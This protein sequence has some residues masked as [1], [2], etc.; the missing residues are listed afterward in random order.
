[1]LTPTFATPVS[2]F[3][4][5]GNTPAVSLIQTLPPHEDARILHLGC[6]DIRNILFTCY[7]N[8]ALRNLD[9]TCCDIECAILARNILLLSVL[10]DDASNSSVNL[11]WNIN[12]HLYLNRQDANSIYTQVDKL[13]DQ[14]DSI[15]TW[16][17]SRYGR[18]FRFCD[19]ESFSKVKETWHS[20]LVA[21]SNEAAYIKKFK[22]SIQKA[23]DIRKAHVG[24]GIVLTGVRSAAP[25]GIYAITD[26]SKLHGYFWEHGSTDSNKDII[27]KSGF[28]NPTFMPVTTSSNLHYGSDPLLGFHL[29]LGY[30]PLISEFSSRADKLETSNF[31]RAV[32]AARREFQMWCS[33][34]KKCADSNLI[35]RF[36]WADALTMCHTLQVVSLNRET[37]TADWYSGAY[38]SD[39]LVLD[40]ED[41]HTTGAAPLSFN[42]IDTSNL[43]DHLGAINLLAA[44]SPLLENTASSSLFTESLVKREKNSTALL[45]NLLSYDF[46]TMTVVLCLYPIEY[47]T[48][49]TSASGFDEGMMDTVHGLMEKDTV[50]SSS[51][52]MRHRILWKR[53]MTAIKGFQVI[54]WKAAELAMMFY[55][56][57]KNMFRH[58]NMQHLFSG[59]DLHSIKNMS[60]PH[61]HRGSLALLL[62]FAKDNCAADWDEVIK[63]FLNLIEKDSLV[64]MTNNYI[65]EFYVYLHIFGVHTVPTLQRTFYENSRTQQVDGLGSWLDLPP[66]VC[67]TLNI[68]KKSLNVLLNAPVKRVGTPILH[69]ILQSSKSST[70]KPWQNIFSEVHLVFGKIVTHG[71][72]NE[73]SFQV[74]IVEDMYGWNGTSNL[75]ASFYIPTWVALFDPKNAIVSLGIQS[76]PPSATYFGPILGLELNL[77][78]T[79][80]ANK[81]NVYITKHYPQLP[82]LPKVGCSIA[83]PPATNTSPSN[84]ISTIIITANMDQRCER[85][86]SF[87]GRLELL[88]NRIKR[89]LLDGAK[90]ET[91]QISMCVMTVS[92]NNVYQFELSFPTGIEGSRRK[93]RIA[94]TSSYV[95]VI[96]PLTNPMSWGNYPDS[97]YPMLMQNNPINFNMPYLC[98]NSLPIIDIKQKKEL[99]WLNTHLSAMWSL[100]ERRQREAG[101]ESGDIRVNFKDSLFSIFMH[102]TALQG[103]KAHIFGINHS[104]RGGIHILIFVNCLRLDMGNQTV[105]LDAAVIP[106]TDRIVTQNSRFFSILPKRGVC[107][108]MVDD[109]ELV[110]WRRVIPAWVERCREWDHK[111]SCEYKSRTQIPLAAKDGENPLCCCG[112]GLLTSQYMPDFPEWKDVSKH[113]LRAAI[114]P[115]FPVPYIEEVFSVDDLREFK[116]KADKCNTCGKQ[117]AN[118]TQLKNCGKC[119]QAKYCSVECQRRDWKAHKKVC[120]SLD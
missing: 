111:P 36:C 95:E 89:T 51:G 106:L 57:Y 35:L 105:V 75:L 50:G 38:R 16:H 77:Y 54:H 120:I 100:R 61:Y 37:R 97:L 10:L 83:R 104:K 27:S 22:T 3:Y 71:S 70:K 115:C 8:T 80:L 55:Q 42:V 29:A 43:V 65:Q 81:D 5:L 62:R 4:P 47:W 93:L 110:L 59:L 48:N 96:V 9:I 30:I 7:S 15:Q 19:Q 88:S 103:Q 99:K 101:N 116:E 113:A 21:R 32:A 17:E 28:P 90:V 34:F 60:N 84:E 91:S 69:C 40:G 20:Y 107:S 26:L 109:A 85:L 67:I 58:E 72:Q 13:L 66:I 23:I 74:S 44:A 78:E 52:Q 108:I 63:N 31:P 87:T 33:T 49:T 39:P 92:I 118:G 94:R 2:F 24:S 18:W 79:Y 14:S 46:A 82:G 76:N 86:E 102:F 68:P 25:A 11:A 56:V 6:G 119:H 64:M 98:L 117:S 41:Y 53:P 12:C 112:T 1:M 45:N 73:D 114:S